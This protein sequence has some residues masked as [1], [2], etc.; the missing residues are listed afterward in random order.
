MAF[1][2]GNL[3][4]ENQIIL[5]PMAGVSN[6]FRKLTRTFGAGLVFCRNGIR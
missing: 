5:A 6:S 1:K 4:I 2:I 3:N